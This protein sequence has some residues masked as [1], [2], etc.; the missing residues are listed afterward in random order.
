MALTQRKFGEGSEGRG[1]RELVRAGWNITEV[2][3]DQICRANA[4]DPHKRVFRLVAAA[5]GDF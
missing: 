2:R 1:G 5:S 3:F 4:P